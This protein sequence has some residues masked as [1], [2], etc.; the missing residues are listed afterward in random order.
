MG[1]LLQVLPLHLRQE[2]C[3]QLLA[4][5]TKH[6]EDLGVAVQLTQA[7]E[8]IEGEALIVS[9]KAGIPHLADRMH[10]GRPALRTSFGFRLDE[11]S[12]TE[13]QQ[14]AANRYGRKAAG[15]G[16]PLRLDAP[17]LFSADAGFASW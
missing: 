8:Y 12:G 7:C 15:L 17:P 9:G 4:A 3:L 14:M 11:A 2:A 16:D 1:P 10:S 5:A 13:T 6:L